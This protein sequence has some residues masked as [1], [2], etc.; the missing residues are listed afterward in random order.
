MIGTAAAVGLFVSVGVHELGH[1]RAAARYG[2]ETASITLRILGGL[3]SLKSMPKEWN[4]G[5]WIALAGRVT[6]VLVGVVAYAV[7]LALP[8]STPVAS[9]VFGWL[10]VTN[11]A[12]AAFVY[13]AAN[14]ESRHVAV[15]SLLEG[16]TA[17]DVMR[18]DAEPVSADAT[19]AA[20]LDRMMRE[21]RTTYTVAD[22]GE[23]VDAVSLSDAKRAATRRRGDASRDVMVEGVARVPA[24]A[25]A[26]EVLA[27]LNDASTG[28]VLVPEA[29]EIAGVATQA[30]FASLL[31]I[32]REGEW[33]L[34]S[35][36]AQ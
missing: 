22:A 20:L 24:D 34:A 13:G 27:L 26:F 32:R 33:L 11:G 16:L 9:F 29:G 17:A 12:L 6:S 25:D 30:E 23:V 35:R 31:Q 36:V 2:V 8:A 21:R 19:L 15:A 3:A 28:V 5:F 10:V 1:A 4:R 14:G 7:V 18:S